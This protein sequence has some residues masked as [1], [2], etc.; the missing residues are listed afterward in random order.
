[1]LHHPNIMKCYDIYQQEDWCYIMT[2]YC[3]EGTLSDFIR[4]KGSLG[5]S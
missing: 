1:M 5:A 4:S 3:N 2:E